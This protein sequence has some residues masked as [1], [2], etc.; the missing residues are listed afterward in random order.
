MPFSFGFS[1]NSYLFKNGTAWALKAPTMQGTANGSLGVAP[2]I[3]LQ[4]GGGNLFGKCPDGV[5]STVIFTNWSVVL[6]DGSSHPLPSSDSVDYSFHSSGY[7]CIN[8]TF[9][10]VTTDGS[11]LTAVISVAGP[12]ASV[13]QGTVYSPSGM[14]ING[15][16]FTSAK[17]SPLAVTDSSGNTVSITST[18]AT[19]FTDSLGLTALTASYATTGNSF[20]W[21]DVNGGTQQVTTTNTNTTLFSSFGCSGVTE[22]SGSQYLPTKVAYPQQTSAWRIR[23]RCRCGMSR[24]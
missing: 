11:G 1:E 10:D 2:G 14:A 24:W 18:A 7:S 20:S 13:I 17:L 23:S 5:T 12:G 6:A 4:S 8:S 19:S 22:I 3:S 16:M 15:V 21:T 9:T